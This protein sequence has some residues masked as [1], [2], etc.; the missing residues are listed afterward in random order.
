M[1]KKGIKVK[2]LARELRITSRVLIDRCRAQGRSVQN[3]ISKLPKDLERDARS[4]FEPQGDA[5]HGCGRGDR[6]D[7]IAESKPAPA[8][9]R[10]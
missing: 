2:D 1:A 9:V 10:P 8:E 7:T 3:R 5:S 4:W 6:G